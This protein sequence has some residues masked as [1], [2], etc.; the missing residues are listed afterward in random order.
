MYIEKIKGPED[1]KKLSLSELELLADELRDVV[2]GTVA[3]NGGHLASNLGTIDLTVALHYV[4]N[5]PEDKIVWDVGHQ[6]YAHKMLTGRYDRFST[7]RKRGG[8]SGFPRIT[9]SPHDAFGTGHSSTS[10]SAALGILE[11]RNHN[12]QGFKVIAVIGDGAMTAGLA[13]EGLNHAGHLKKD[14]IVILNDNEM[15]ISPNVGALS[16]YLRRIMMGDLYT[17]FKKETKH[18]LERIPRVGEPVLK[19]AQRAEDTVKGFFVPG[20]LFEE[21]GFEYVGPV[22]GHKIDQLVETLERFR[23]FPGPVLIH[24]I[25]RKGKGYEPAEKNP[26]MFHGL[27]PFDIET[28]RPAGSAGVSYSSV[29]GSA[30]TELAGEDEKIVAITAAMTEGTGLSSFVEAFPG[31][32][33]DVGIAE[34][35]AVTFAAGLA[36]QGLKPV[37]AVYS[38]FL[39][40]SYDEI[41]HDVCLQNLHVIFAIDRGGIVG[42]D[43]PTHNGTFD[44]SF[45]R[46]IP[47]LVIMAP[48][49]GFELRCMLK[50]AVAYNGPIAVRYPR[51]TAP[52]MPDDSKPEAIPV[53]QSELL[54][55]GGDILIIAIGS[56]VLP[57]VEAAERLEKEYGIQCTVI[58]A[59]FVKPLD[60]ALI[61]RFARDIRHII[62]V[63]ENAVAGGFGSAVL[64]DLVR[65]GIE[66]FKF[67]ILGLPDQ[68]I[69]HGPQSVLRKNLG[70]DA[71]GIAREALAMHNEK[72]GVSAKH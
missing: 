47:N 38:T 31:R 37:V 46:H 30:I 71:D 55:K 28:G 20:Q 56:T 15:S 54:R 12:Q 10:I 70:I 61:A 35:H 25:T 16:A 4:F 23:D 11:G 62:T 65:S 64:E 67:K 17:R 48:K 34:P 60:T 14:L 33:Y 18:F 40:R 1:L 19:I 2:I 50:T 5:S 7:I 27:G 21:L 42:D 45:L 43:G 69:E 59:R 53:G 57:S 52:D 29:F 58:N 24:A 44:L 36:T 72:P 32:F 8:I 68:F 66:D 39:Q 6:A 51:G 22:D 49:D 9:E 13:F 26:G 41:I 63:E 3:T